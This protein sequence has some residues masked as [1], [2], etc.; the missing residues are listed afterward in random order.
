MF[1]SS[2]QRLNV[3]IW[4]QIVYYNVIQTLKQTSRIIIIIN[5]SINI[6]LIP[7]EIWMAE[8]I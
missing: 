5:I 8:N 1:H 2:L 4:I 3:V 7:Q 6:I